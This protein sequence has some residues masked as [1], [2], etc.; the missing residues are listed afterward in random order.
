MTYK[1][2]HENIRDA[3]FTITTPFS[4]DGD[5][6]LT[7]RL[8]E[9]VQM[10]YDEGVRAFVPCGNT[11][12][13]YSLSASERISVVRTTVEALPNDATIIAGAGGSVGETRDLLNAYIDAGTDAAMIMYPRHTYV[14]ERG[15]I[16]YYRRLAESTDLGIVLYKRGPL[17][18]ET[19]LD[20]LSEIKNIVGIKFAVND[21]SQFSRLNKSISGN[22]E[23]IN[24][25]AERYALA[26]TL[27]GADGFT[28]G[29]G[30]FVP[31]QVLALFDALLSSDWD[32]AKKIRDSLRPLEEIRD[33]AGGSPRFTAAKNVPVVKHGLDTCGMYGG[34]VRTPLVD[35]S[36]ADRNRVD[37]CLDQ[38]SGTVD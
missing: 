8:A 12:E 21:V 6:V 9:N 32:R 7:D 17:L 4:E 36:P 20:T 2:L 19:I 29:I 5:K 11:G 28:T 15:L 38:L 13:Y 24:G 23:L 35:L 18:N 34:P 3:L 31:T 10:L 27:E 16:N 33:E 14:H 25:V 26:Y 37:Q 30:N 1:R 22:V